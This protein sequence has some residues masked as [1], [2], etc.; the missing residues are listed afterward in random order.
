MDLLI[1][2]VDGYSLTLSQTGLSSGIGGVAWDC[3]LVL[4]RLLLVPEFTD[5]I[6]AAVM[7][8]AVPQ[9]GSESFSSMTALELGSGTGLVGMQ[10]AMLGCKSI[11]TD[12]PGVMPQ[13]AVNLAQNAHMLDNCSV[14]ADVYVWGQPPPLHHFPVHLL[15][16]SD[17]LYQFEYVELLSGSLRDIF[18]KEGQSPLI[19][20]AY[21]DRNPDVWSEFLDRVGDFLAWEK[22]KL[23]D[24][25]DEGELPPDVCVVLMYRKD[26]IA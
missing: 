17:C 26:S 22:V 20:H 3:G 9:P 25:L 19:L 2:T 6:R 15:V 10:L 5:R 7:A 11:L 21:E 8:R 1:E 12:L 13:L 24:Y 16:M 23:S 18:C 4:S 14:V